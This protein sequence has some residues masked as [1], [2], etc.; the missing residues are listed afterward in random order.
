MGRVF[1]AACG[2]RLDLAHV[3]RGD[4]AERGPRWRWLR[5]TLGILVAVGVVAA[6]ALALWPAG[7]EIGVRGV[8]GDVRR[9]RENLGTLSVLRSGRSLGC[10]FLEKDINAFLYFTKLR[11]MKLLAFSVDVTPGRVHVR[12]IRRLGPWQAGPVRLAP[13]LSVDL[14]CEP[15]DGRLAARGA[16]VGRLPLCGPAKIPAV[17]WVHGLVSDEQEWQILKSLS[18]V[19]AEDGRIAV[20]LGR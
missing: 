5:R 1:C 11:K 12:V 17:K 9:V 2:A 4:M 13:R 6:G 18:E 14:I 16:S 8:R 7:G 3:S 10:E 19:R 20:V 15:A